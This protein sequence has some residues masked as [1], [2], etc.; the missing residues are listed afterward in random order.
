MGLIESLAR[1]QDEAKVSSPS[2][3]S[4]PRAPRRVAMQPGLG[5]VATS[6]AQPV[7][8]I[9]TPARFSSRGVPMPPPP[10]V[11]RLPATGSGPE[12]PVPAQPPEQP[13]VPW[14]NA[15]FDELGAAITGATGVG[16]VEDLTAAAPGAL[17][18]VLTGP[19]RKV[20]ELKGEIGYQLAINSSPTSRAAFLQLIA[21]LME[22]GNVGLAGKGPD[23]VRSYFSWIS[24]HNEEVKALYA[25]G[26][27]L[28]VWGAFA[29]ENLT[30]DLSA[31]LGGDNIAGIASGALSDPWNIASLVGPGMAAQLG[32][33]GLANQVVGRVGQALSAPDLIV[34][35]GMKGAGRLV[36]PIADDVR[37]TR[38]GAGIAR[39]FDT[40][41]RAKAN[42]L[43][44]RLMRAIK[45]E[46]AAGTVRIADPNA[47][48]P[49]TSQPATITANA[50]FV[51]YERVAKGQRGS[52]SN[53]GEAM[54]QRLR[55]AA[56]G[57]QAA[58]AAG[59]SAAQDAIALLNDPDVS[60]NSYEFWRAGFEAE[61]SVRQVAGGQAG[62]H[63]NN[64]PANS[65]QFYL[66][67]LAWNPNPEARERARLWLNAR[68]AP[69]KGGVTAKS[70]AIALAEGNTHRPQQT[71]PA[72]ST[73]VPERPQ[74]EQPQWEL[75]LPEDAELLRL[76]LGSAGPERQM[77]EAAN[78]SLR[79][80]YDFARA[81]ADKVARGAM[82]A[83][84]GAI[85]AARFVERS[86]YV[87][88]LM[89]QFKRSADYTRDYAARM[90][91][92][93]PQVE[94]VI[95]PF[96]EAADV[97]DRSVSFRGPLAD[98]QAGFLQQI[99]S[100]TNPRNRGR[101]FGEVGRNLRQQ[102]RR[103]RADLVR[104][105]GQ[106]ED[107][108][109]KG[110]RAEAK[111]LRKLQ[112]LYPQITTRKQALAI[113][114]EQMWR[115][116]MRTE[117]R[118]HL[119]VGEA[120]RFWRGIDTLSSNFSTLNLLAPWSVARYYVGNLSGD[121][122]QVAMKLGADA[123]LAVGDPRAMA[124]MVD[125]AVRGGDPLNSALGRA[126]TEL[127]LG[128]YNPATMG[129]NI[130]EAMFDRLN[131]TMR[132]A[133]GKSTFNIS[134]RLA[135]YPYFRQARSVS[136][137]LE[138][139][140]RTSLHG[141]LL[142]KKVVAARVDYIR[143]MGPLAAKYGIDSRE[144]EQQVRLLGPRF[145]G[146]D[147][148]QAMGNL[149]MSKGL[150]AS[151]VRGLAEEM[152][153]KWA[154][155][156]YRADDEALKA[157][158][159]ALF[160]YDPTNLD[161]WARR[162]VPFHMWASRA[163]PFYAEQGMRNP[164]F[165]HGYYSLVQQTKEQ[166][167]R[168]GWPD[169]L[170]MYARFWEGPGGIMLFFSPM[171]A[172][173][174]MDLPL[175]GPERSEYD[176]PDNAV[177]EIL[178]TGRTFGFGLLPI[179]SWM[180]DSAGLLGDG[181]A[182]DPVGIYQ[183]EN[184]LRIQAQNAVAQGWLGDEYR[185]Y[186]GRPLESMLQRVRAATSGW[187]SGIG[188]GEHIPEGHAEAGDL[189]KIRGRM[190]ENELAERGLGM[191][192][193]WMLT[194]QAQINPDGPEAD[195]VSEIHASVAD[196]FT[197][198]NAAYLRALEEVS[199]GEVGASLIRAVLPG[200]KQV[201]QRTVLEIQGMAAAATDIA[202]GGE[203]FAPGLGEL[204]DGQHGDVANYGFLDPR[205]RAFLNAWAE[206]FGQDYRKGDLK[207][208]M[209]AA[210]REN[211]SQNISPE[212]STI[213]DQRFAYE[214]LGS[215]WEQRMLAKYYAIANGEQGVKLPFDDLDL[216]AAQVAAQDSDVRWALADAWLEHRNP[217]GEIKKLREAQ[218]VFE[219]SYPEYGGWAAWRRDSRKQWG[220]ARAFRLAAV[221]ANPN[222]AAFINRETARLRDKGRTPSQI[223]EALDQYI[224]FSMEAYFA[225]QGKR[226]NQYDPEPLET[227]AP[228]PVASEGA[229]VDAIGNMAGTR[230]SG[231]GGGSVAWESR[232][233]T[234]ITEMHAA[235]KRQFELYGT[236]FD[237]MPEE[238]AA[239]LR[240]Q[241]PPEA[242]EPEDSWIFWDYAEFWELA[243]QA[244]EP[245][246]ID[247]FIVFTE[248]Q[249]EEE[250]QLDVISEVKSNL[251]LQ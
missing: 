245:N 192:E 162:F 133:G 231:G 97:L 83:E 90:Q 160:D 16:G 194:I 151:D 48:T 93:A 19:M 189:I 182:Q 78:V 57:D 128:G 47:I 56:G 238:I 150:D 217:S 170:R 226:W 1:R 15:R 44:E 132:K 107:L 104:L 109:T 33:A 237:Q 36:R 11:T 210:W 187:T 111:R 88:G 229:L 102:T 125:Y 100:E 24:L 85:D 65:I 195:A 117:F 115:D 58:A 232:V 140:R 166:S 35:A 123:V 161:K 135:E 233:R 89:E 75:L 21:P 87:T 206:K 188:I 216:S 143:E 230:A 239:A 249:R 73:A 246:D 13:P 142:Q 25:R 209:E 201:R 124:V 186:L 92:P 219:E 242:I 70:E 199:A 250:E 158:N 177:Q 222:Y 148:A 67:E 121:T 30:V 218:G 116:R 240:V 29:D 203:A 91:I 80:G 154:N 183:A 54:Q 220:G 118:E 130:S 31:G 108:T 248:Q 173:G 50:P 99:F 153:R 76:G 10:V 156:V 139:G 60:A 41:P 7:R 176:Q 243:G 79:K 207:R 5:G 234:A 120:N 64:H 23:A 175:F 174:L 241:A 136:N 34:G 172:V 105:L 20:D 51:A 53:A 103:D 2:S 45:Q 167:E 52:I 8:R 129:E 221:R 180:L 22:A 164:G 63:V 40:E 49:A 200:P 236:T 197:D 211:Q 179:W 96:V 82:S 68:S 55:A 196:D 39:W 110:G 43:T 4:A 71:A 114:D 208:L 3:P 113:T 126:Y 101:T 244:G 86:S 228:L 66:D 205:A 14:L 98:E 84:Q 95:T 94:A 106:P 169:T 190:L 74:Y 146:A 144:L 215:K 37:K 17:D 235:R 247:A 137:G 145:S 227:G 27:G 213:Y 149:A 61:V 202:S 26:G 141:H 28:A 32:R 159:S 131:G 193:Y 204:P 122:A 46:E 12:Q 155:R 77:F 147:V 178:Q 38:V 134:T 157:V 72:T 223:D 191:N 212:A 171:A 165:A 42:N 214:A 119:N 62:R 81:S 127:G 168:E 18:T 251:V 225:Y 112:A 185:G 152:G 69:K 198:G 138:W 9:V 224:T 181:P 184:F 6:D 163:L 59:V